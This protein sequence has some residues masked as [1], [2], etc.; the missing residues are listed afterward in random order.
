MGVWRPLKLK[1]QQMCVETW[2]RELM[3]VSLDTPNESM[4]FGAWNH[5]VTMTSEGRSQLQFQK[6]Q[7][8]DVRKCIAALL[9]RW[10]L[11]KDCHLG[12]VGRTN[13]L[14]QRAVPAWKIYEPSRL[15]NMSLHIIHDMQDKS[16][17]KYVRTDVSRLD[18]LYQGSGWLHHVKSM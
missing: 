7:F 12:P 5:Q 14:G 18:D 10:K 1:P 6:L 16:A 3:V 17:D 11:G 9:A 8:L 15:L 4:L 13:P 2:L